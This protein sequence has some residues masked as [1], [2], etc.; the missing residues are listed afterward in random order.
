LS[1]EA[2]VEAGAGV[3]TGA[4]ARAGTGVEA[5]AGVEAGTGVETGAAAPTQVSIRAAELR[6]AG[7]YADLLI[8][9]LAESGK[10]GVPVFAPGHRPSREEVR[11]N[12][13]ARWARRL[14]D[15][16]WGR[17]WFLEAEGAG[18]VGHIELRGGR[19]TPELHRATLGMGILQAYTGRGYGKLLL[20]TAIGW[21]R[22]ETDLAWIDLGVF[23]GNT[24]AIKLY[25]RY[26]FVREFAREDA[27]R[28]PD[29]TSI[30]D[31]CMTLKIR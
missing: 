22:A 12:A 28:L 1:G 19:I 23:I 14:T 21:A 9:H 20:D 31:I 10:N 5:G 7:A 13:A 27:F 29:G 25:E 8:A 2:G 30:T 15:P 18:L 17:E 3:E 6:D 4:A 24:P 11:D 16:V 26:G